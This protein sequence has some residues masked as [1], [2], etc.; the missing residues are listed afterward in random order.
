MRGIPGHGPIGGLTI[1]T[2]KITAFQIFLP[3]SNLEHELIIGKVWLSGEAKRKEVSLPFVGEYGQ[4]MHDDW[5]GKLKDGDEFAERL[6]RERLA[7]ASMP[8]LNGRDTYG[9]WAEGPQ[10]EATGWFRTEKADGRW[11]LITPEG[12]LFF[13][14]GINCVGTG[15]YTFIE[16][17]DGWYAWLPDE[18]EGP[19]S[20]MYGYA[21]NVHS[22]AEP[23]G[24]K[25]RTFNFYG[26]NLIRKYGENW[27]EPWREMVYARLTAWGF[28]TI[29]NWSDK[30]VLEHTTIP[31]TATI[32]I[33]NVP[34]VEGAT[35]YWS[36]MKDVYAPDFAKRVDQKVASAASRYARSPYCVGYFVDNE[37]AWHGIKRGTLDSPVDQPC[38]VALIATL[39]DKYGTIVGLNRAW[40]HDAEHWDGLNTPEKLNAAA[41]TDLNEFVYRFAN[42]YFL[43]IHDALKKHAPNQLYLGC[44]FGG[45]EDDPI[46][47]KACAEVVD[48]ISY[49]NYSHGVA[50]PRWG[51]VNKL[52]K[53][54]VIG[55]FHFGS[56]DRGMFHPGLVATEH[57]N[58]RAKAYADYVRSVADHPAFVGCHWFQFLDQP[59]TGR[60]LDGENF[61]IG[62]VTVTD[63]PYPE[64]VAAAQRIHAEVYTL[65]QNST[66]K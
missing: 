32:H 56:L 8:R 65:H 4:F 49:N 43:I 20:T 31:F 5:P 23:I 41:Q 13:S 39:K 27:K 15:A 22:W 63:T 25:G 9:G 28:N 12:H 19:F 1:D 50:G 45:W 33:K 11:W 6:S 62:F 34:L 47:E 37:L 59:A 30:E 36:K 61:N 10:L 40:D 53:P 58:A 44:R 52:N 46:V 66:S 24:G 57:Q 21:E 29:A 17:R 35:G 26:V 18:K 3:R 55:E 16:G 64:M 14:T 2:S 38:R 42:R 60:N 48:V 54:A 7:L 51:Q